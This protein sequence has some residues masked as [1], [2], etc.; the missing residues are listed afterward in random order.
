MTPEANSQLGGDL[1]TWRASF[2]EYDVP[3][4]GKNTRDRTCESVEETERL[5]VLRIQGLS[6]VKRGIETMQKRAMSDDPERYEARYRVM[7]ENTLKFIGS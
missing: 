1:K 2:R 6:R 4:K 3:V 5:F 7:Y